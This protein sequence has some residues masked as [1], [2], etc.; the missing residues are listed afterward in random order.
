MLMTR[1]K[2][3]VQQKKLKFMCYI[4]KYFIICS[5]I[6]IINNLKNFKY[7]KLFIIHNK[8][9]KYKLLII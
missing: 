6:D 3:F 8:N 2:L 1:K 4:V 9:K 7:K 5:L